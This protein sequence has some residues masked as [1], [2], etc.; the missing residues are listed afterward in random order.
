MRL[1]PPSVLAM[2]SLTSHSLARGR[3][4]CG[5]ATLV[6]LMTAIGIGSISMAAI[7]TVLW[8]LFRSFVAM[9]NYA[10]LDKASRSALDQMSRDIRRASYLVSSATNQLVFNMGGTTNLTFFWDPSTR[11]LTR[12]MTGQPD[13]ILLKECDYLLFNT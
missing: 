1:N 7:S 5:G 10:D 2:K 13:T 6:E 11:Q 3:R 9:G 4:S 12:S 8:Y